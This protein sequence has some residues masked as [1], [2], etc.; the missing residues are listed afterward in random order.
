MKQV[1]CNKCGKVFEVE[2]NAEWGYCPFCENDN[3]EVGKERLDCEDICP[4]YY[5][6][7]EEGTCMECCEIYNRGE[8]PMV[9]VN[10]LEKQVADLEAKLAEQQKCGLRASTK[11]NLEMQNAQICI[12]E[13]E[14]KLAKHSQDKILFCI[15]KL[16]DVRSFV[17]D[18]TEIKE[19][20]YT[21]VCNYVEK[22]IEELKKEIK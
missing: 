13:L 8:C 21:K 14:A 3:V 22:Q 12:K 11:H 6:S 19:P 20:D 2:D 9:Y 10:D 15:E 4:N 16:T 5:S 1:E 7:W 17:S 18:A